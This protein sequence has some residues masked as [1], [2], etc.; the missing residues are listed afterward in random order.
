MFFFYYTIYDFS[1]F[2]KQLR[3]INT[4]YLIVIQKYHLY[5]VSPIPNEKETT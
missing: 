3:K 2:Q 1:V 5:V 4:Y